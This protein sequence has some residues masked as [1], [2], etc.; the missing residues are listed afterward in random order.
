MPVANCLEK[1]FRNFLWNESIELRKY[2]LVIWNSICGPFK[3]GG[4]GIRMTR[5]HSRALMGNGYGVLD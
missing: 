2:H 5:N 4:L 3:L 1:L